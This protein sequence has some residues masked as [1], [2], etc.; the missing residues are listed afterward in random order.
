MIDPVA[1]DGSSRRQRARRGEGDRLREEILAA[2]EDLLLETGDAEKVSI[3]AL[4]DAVGVTPP[5]IYLHFADKAALLR[6]VCENRFAELEAAL[7]EAAPPDEAPLDVLR[8]KGR[9]YVRFGT[10]HPEHYRLLFMLRHEGGFEDF[11]VGAGAFL[12]LVQ[13]V[14][15]Y[16]DAG[17]YAPGDAALVATSLWTTMHGITS[18]LISLPNFPWPDVDALVDHTMDVQA[19]GLAVDS[20]GQ[21]GDRS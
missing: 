1:P 13:D 7:V 6:T 3:R 18:L 14:Q 10:E 5:S 21:G 8:R 4:A 15:H 16:M 11:P 12:Q 17:V 2:A 9:A 20:S 19:R